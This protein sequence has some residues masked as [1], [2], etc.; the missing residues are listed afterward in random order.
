MEPLAGGVQRLG[1][2]AAQGGGAVVVVVCVDPAD[3]SVDGPH[4]ADPDP[5]WRVLPGGP[6]REKRQCGTRAVHHEGT[7]VHA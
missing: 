4:V 2:S 3:G 6:E 1:G 7:A 5:A